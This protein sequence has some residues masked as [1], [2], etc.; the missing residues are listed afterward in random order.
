MIKDKKIASTEEELRIIEWWNKTDVEIKQMYTNMEYGWK[1]GYKKLSYQQVKKL[2][3][4][5]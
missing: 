1:K 5:A 2:Y 4:K 3:K